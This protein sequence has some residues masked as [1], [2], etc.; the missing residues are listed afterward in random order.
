MYT[1][2][3]NPPFFC[4]AL[5]TSFARITGK[6]G[7]DFTMHA[8]ARTCVQG[9]VI[10]VWNTTSGD[11][12]A[13]LRRGKDTASI[14]NLVF[15]LDSRWLAVSSDRGTVHIFDLDTPPPDAPSGLLQYIGS[16][17]VL[18]AGVSEY[19]T[20]WFSKAKIHLPDSAPACV[21]AFGRTPGRVFVVDAEGIYGV[22][23]FDVDKGGEARV[24]DRFLFG[25][26]D[27]EQ[28]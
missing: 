2:I 16:T 24:V 17:G 18:G 9:T 20:G 10:R 23:D 12:R 3:A 28:A 25:N 27:R 11:K 14:N 7:V 22:Y 6:H 21:C 13:E 1:R 8:C 26:E 5:M 19:S 15:S 4:L